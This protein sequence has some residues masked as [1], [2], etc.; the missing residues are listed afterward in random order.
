M[1]VRS[2]S[3]PLLPV[4]KPHRQNNASKGITH[5]RLERRTPVLLELP[6]FPSGDYACIA[7]DFLDF[8]FSLVPVA[9]A[10]VEVRVESFEFVRAI[11]GCEL[12]SWWKFV[13]GSG[14][15]RSAARNGDGE[16]SENEEEG[17]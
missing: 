2:L 9:P 5:R 10:E 4:D 6:V 16:E 14:W 8:L 3:A 1:H 7:D 11:P 15:G 12:V 13:L 17:G